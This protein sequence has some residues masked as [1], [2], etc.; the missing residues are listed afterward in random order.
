MPKIDQLLLKYVLVEL[1][2]QKITMGDTK[3]MWL[4]P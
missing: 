3:N 4:I 2:N 1:M